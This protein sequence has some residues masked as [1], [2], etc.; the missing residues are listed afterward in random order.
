MYPLAGSVL[1]LH[2]ARTQHTMLSAGGKHRSCGDE[3]RVVVDA[4]THLVFLR[5]VLVLSTQ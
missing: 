5:T 1:E 4:N 3:G 2:A